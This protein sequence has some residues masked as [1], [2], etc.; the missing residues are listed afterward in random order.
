MLM[1]SPLSKARLRN[2][3]FSKPRVWSSE[4]DER[5]IACPCL[6]RVLAVPRCVPL[7]MLVH[8]HANERREKRCLRK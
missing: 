6:P 5:D 3:V 1:P 2:R 4:A 7:A 8:R